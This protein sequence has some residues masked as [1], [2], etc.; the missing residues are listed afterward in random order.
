MEDQKPGV[1]QDQAVTQQAAPAET[2]AAEKEPVA[3]AGEVVEPA[4]GDLDRKG[5]LF[6]IQK[7]RADK[8]RLKDELD[9][10]TGQ[11]AQLRPSG[12]QPPVQDM[13][14]LLSGESPDVREVVRQEL[15]KDRLATEE[16]QATEYLLSQEDVNQEQGDLKA[17]GQVIRDYKLERL[18]K[19][20][21]LEAVQAGLELWRSKRTKKVDPRLKAEAVGA[22]RSAGP[23][24]SVTP[25]N[26]KKIWSRDEIRALSR[27][28]YVAHRDDILAASREGRIKV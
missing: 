21:P 18:M 11:L 28:E 3:A 20:H 23:S 6:T 17:I 4:E 13:T 7:L 8:R 1:T 15:A 25:S 5:L 16:D 12:V 26:G 9:Q 2:P 22:P 27:E 10:A 24:P 19:E 14:A